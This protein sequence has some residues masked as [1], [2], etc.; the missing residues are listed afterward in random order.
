MDSSTHSPDT[1]HRHNVFGARAKMPMGFT[2]SRPP[3]RDVIRGLNKS[4]DF[5]FIFIMLLF[6]I[7][8]CDIDALL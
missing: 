1:T 2:H 4:S 5:F 8:I 3:L 6:V 7:G